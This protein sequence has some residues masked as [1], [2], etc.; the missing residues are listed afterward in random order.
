MVLLLPGYCENTE[1]NKLKGII[2]TTDLTI[3]KRPITTFVQYERHPEGAKGLQEAKE[4]VFSELTNQSFK[5]LLRDKIGL[6]SLYFR[7]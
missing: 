6:L 4:F 3:D 7:E 5:E 1:K 2:E